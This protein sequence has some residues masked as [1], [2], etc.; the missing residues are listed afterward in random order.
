[1]SIFLG[2]INTILSEALQRNLV[3]ANSVIM[4]YSLKL[5]HDQKQIYF[6]AIIYYEVQEWSEIR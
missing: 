4:H 3:V 2:F 6:N 1:M 5:K